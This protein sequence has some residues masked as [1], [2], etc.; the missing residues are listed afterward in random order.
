MNMLICNILIFFGGTKLQTPFGAR[1]Q[2]A[3]TFEAQGTKL[4]TPLKLRV[5]N[6]RHLYC[7]KYLKAG[8]FKAKGAKLQTSLPAINGLAKGKGTKLQ[9][10]LPAKSHER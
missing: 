5:P 7:E 8:T 2:I 1:C 6:C 4:Q 3:D 9:T 10:S